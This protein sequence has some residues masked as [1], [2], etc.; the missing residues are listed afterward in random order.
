[1]SNHGNGL[2][3]VPDPIG[4][5]IAAD[6]APKPVTMTA[7]AGEFGESGR[8]FQLGVPQD[9]SESEAYALIE[10]ITKV[11]QQVVNN[12]ARRPKVW[13]PG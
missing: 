7:I 13:T 11:R 6:A 9:L 2:R 12:E 4:A 3:A 5:A 8:P 10:L 1:M